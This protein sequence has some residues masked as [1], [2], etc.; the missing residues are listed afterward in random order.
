MWHS[1]DTAA[2]EMPNSNEALNSFSSFNNTNVFMSSLHQSLNEK[3]VC[4]VSPMYLNRRYIL[5]FITAGGVAPGVFTGQQGELSVAVI[6]QIYKTVTSCLTGILQYTIIQKEWKHPTCHLRLLLFWFLIDLM[7]Q[8][9]LK[10][11]Y[12][13]GF[14]VDLKKKDVN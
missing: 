9:C 1:T 14:M 5:V 7:K 13:G 11:V 10:Q 3:P 8:Y 4:H 12:D 2:R 6:H